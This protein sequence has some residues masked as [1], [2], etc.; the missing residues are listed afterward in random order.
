MSVNSWYIFF[1]KKREKTTEKHKAL[2]P[3]SIHWKALVPRTSSVPR[4][5]T[6]VVPK[7]NQGSLR[8]GCRQVCRRKGWTRAWNTLLHQKARELLGPCPENSQAGLR[9][10]FG[11]VAKNNDYNGLK[12]IKSVKIHECIMTPLPSQILLVALGDWVATEATRY[13]ENF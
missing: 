5:T 9:G 11:G 8:N 4:S 12:Y 2:L 13:S 7:R 1:K 10:W 3:L 6:T